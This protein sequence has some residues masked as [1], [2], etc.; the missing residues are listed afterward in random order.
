M[1]LYNA[2]MCCKLSHSRGLVP[3]H[4]AC[5]YGHYEVANLLVK[6][7]MKNS[8]YASIFSVSNPVSRYNVSSP[9]FF[10]PAILLN[11]MTFNF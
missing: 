4:N 8:C 3:L 6:V 9:L 10:Y 2:N 11:N 7:R 5:S 1:V